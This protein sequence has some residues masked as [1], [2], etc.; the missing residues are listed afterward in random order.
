MTS[1]LAA[2]IAARRSCRDF[3]D[4]AITRDDLFRILIA[5]AGQTDHGRKRAAPSAERHYPIRLDVV[6]RAVEGMAPG[7]YAH[8]SK[9]QTL[10]YTSDEDIE[11]G[12]VAAALEKQPWLGEAAVVLALSAGVQA[13]CDAFAH[14]GQRGERYVY[15]ETGAMLQNAHLQAT[16]LGLGAVIVAGFDDEATRLALA[17]PTDYCPTA[18]LCIGHSR[19]SASG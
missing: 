6:V 13:E 9:N 10:D 7:I 18:L 8:Q 11:G 2:L 12:L 3:S 1:H 15:I 5:A 17:L 19:N 4:T 14:Q 16:E